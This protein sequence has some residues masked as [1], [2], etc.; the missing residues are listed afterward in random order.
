MKILIL[1]LILIY[2]CKNANSTNLFDTSFYNI[3]FNSNNIEENKIKKIKSIKTES[4]KSIFKKTLNEYYYEEVNNNLT[5][6]LT[7][8]FIR[9]VI[10]NDEII[11]NDKYKSKIKVN[12]NK[13]KIIDYF[14]SK[15]IPYVEFHPDKFLLIIY[16]ND[17]IDDNLFSKNNKYYKYINNNLEINNFFQ[18]PNLDI[19]DR[20]ILKKEDISNRDLNKINNF[21]KKYKSIENIIVIIHNDES[22]PTYDLILNSNGNILEKK[23]L[24]KKYEMNIFFQE[25]QNQTLNLWKLLNEIQN[26]KLN[27]IV[28]RVSYFNIMELKEIRNNLRN[29]SIIN[30]LNI[31]EISYRNIIYDI[32]YYGNLNILLKIFKL[33]KLKISNNQNE[34]IIRLT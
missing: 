19:N 29:V 16:E 22:N 27:N 31:R 20:F 30:D 10:I 9:N 24:L 25:I 23:L 5:E 34:C 8:T 2:I 13:K 4:I 6:D 26:K 33:N 15:K 17:K 12:Y 3:E 18:I 1:I 21:S 14:R 32:N 11:I 7:N 28:C